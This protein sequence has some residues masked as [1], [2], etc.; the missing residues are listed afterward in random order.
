MTTDPPQFLGRYR[1]LRVLGRGAMGVVYEALDT[2]LGRSVAIKTVL[3]SFLADDSTSADYAARFEREAQAAARLSHPH[4][5]TVFDFGE[6]DDA[7]YIVMEFV[8]GRELAQAFDSGEVFA[9]EQIV[10]LMCQLLDALGAAHAQG[11]VH[12]DVKPANVMLDSSGHVKLADF[13]VA[14]LVEGNQERTLPGTLVG[15][16]SYMSPEQIL[17]QAVGSRTDLF[18][19]GVV[20]YQFLTGR[21]P[22]HGTGTY[23]LQRAILQ[24]EPV[25]P[26]LLNAARPAAF[27]AVVARALAKAPEHRHANAAAF[28]AD[29][30]N[31]LAA[32][33]NDRT[34]V[35]PKGPE[36]AATPGAREPSAAPS[37][38]QTLAPP[39]A[40]A[41][42]TE[43][44][45]GF[46]ANDETLMAG[47]SEP[48]GSAW[49][50]PANGLPPAPVGG[51]S[52]AVALAAQ[53]ANPGAAPLP[54]AALAPAALE[55]REPRKTPEARESRS[56]WQSQE[57]P[58]NFKATA[59]KTR[60][61]GAG[62]NRLWWLGGA[63]LALLVG[64]AVLSTCSR[65]RV[66]S[67][68]APAA[69]GPSASASPGTVRPPAAE[70][71]QPP[72][73]PAPPPTRIDPSPAAV[74][75]RAQAPASSTLPGNMAL[76]TPLPAPPPLQASA[77]TATPTARTRP[78]QERPATAPREPAAAATR[79]PAATA[80]DAR[81]PELLTRIQLGDTLTPEQSTFFHTRCAR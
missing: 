29:L 18:A 36:L 46:D 73:Q 53:A 76:P 49:N 79:P 56:P 30:Q 52:P 21:K 51:P 60:P 77:P 42:A 22:F 48:A 50:R 23:G 14:R 57:A 8:R 33:V 39:R 13:G 62:A 35:L 58:Q 40:M 3:R 66:L 71:A 70:A 37:H 65:P 19:A 9:I 11:I 45:P 17:G 80:Q 2:R 41:T 6:Q 64:A 26:S 5:V 69:T 7:S 28:A 34:V 55:S 75:P 67:N 16:P 24:D 25:R 12:R 1:L 63:V 54:A 47:T 15:T 27:D 10:S 31:A 43:V 61:L 44:T 38:L 32:A 4:I 59:P 72:S 20:L 78:P 74:A 81:C 68:Q